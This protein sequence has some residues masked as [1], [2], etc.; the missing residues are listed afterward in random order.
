MCN[1]L[2]SDDKTTIDRLFR[3]WFIPSMVKLGMENSNR[4]P[5][6][7]GRSLRRTA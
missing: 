2:K 1:V 6:L 3:E 4:M 7:A 5:R